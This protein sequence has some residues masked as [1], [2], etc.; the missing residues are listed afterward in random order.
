[1]N[2]RTF[3][4]QTSAQAAAM[5][6]VTLFG[7]SSAHAQSAAKP[8]DGIRVIKLSGTPRER[9][10]QHGETL[11]EIIQPFLGVWAAYLSQQAGV[12]AEAFVQ[13]FLGNTDFDKAME[14]WTPDLLEELA[15]IAEGAD[16]DPAMLMAFNLTDEQWWY[17]RLK[18]AGADLAELRGCTSL[19]F[20]RGPDTPPVIAQNMDI[21]SG[22]EGFEVLLHIDYPDSELQAYVFSVAGML[23]IMGLNNAPVGVCNNSLRQLDVAV[24]GLP[25]NAVTR[26]ILAQP[27]YQAAVDFVQNVKHASGQNYI[28]GGPVN[29][30]SFECSAG[31]VVQFDPP[32]LDGVV[33]HTNHPLVNEDTDLAQFMEQ[34]LSDNP[35]RL[36]SSDARLQI[37]EERLADLPEN[38]DP[39]Y[40]KNILMSRDNAELPVCRP[41]NPDDL[42][43]T[44]T[45]ASVVMEMTTPPVLHLAP[46][47]PSETDFQVYRFA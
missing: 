11:R 15:G 5:A 22:S 38:I 45:A 36:T 3:L 18:M 40:I 8:E 33:Y 31:A 16:V 35:A 4:K 2:R 43:A 13:D 30:I 17:A 1:M 28:L 23:G 20:E 42:G 7:R 26:G 46:G 27:H 39:A 12:P 25:V 6:A 41:H 47:P 37:V 44:F 24:D 32:A 19:G 9:G 34:A 14:R 29:V 21:A 10:R